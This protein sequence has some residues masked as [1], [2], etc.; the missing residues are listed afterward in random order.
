MMPT[1]QM[2]R[3]ANEHNPLDTS[4]LSSNELAQTAVPVCYTGD[5]SIFFLSQ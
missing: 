2:L 4:Y 5:F 1:T 3:E